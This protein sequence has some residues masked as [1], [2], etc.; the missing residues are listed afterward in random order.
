V[1]RSAPR[2]LPSSEHV[3]LTTTPPA[4]RHLPTAAG[5]PCSP[6]VQKLAPPHAYHRG[7][8]PTV[9]SLG[10]RRWLPENWN[11]WCLKWCR[12]I[13]LHPSIK[14]IRRYPIDQIWWYSAAAFYTPTGTLDM[15]L[16][17]GQVH[18]AQKHSASQGKVNV[19]QP[20]TASAALTDH[21]SAASSAGRGLLEEAG[22]ALFSKQASLKAGPSEACNRQMPVERTKARLEVAISCVWILQSYTPAKRSMPTR[23]SNLCLRCTAAFCCAGRRGVWQKQHLW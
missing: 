12:R 6:L 17:L 20:A 16:M 3:S 4:P 15:M 2:V 7:M 19:C 5:V 10:S 21:G 8:L 23:E 14:S 1:P 18:A 9:G 11:A 22:P 13:H